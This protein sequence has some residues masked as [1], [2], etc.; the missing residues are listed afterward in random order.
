MGLEENAPGSAEEVGVSSCV[1]GAFSGGLLGI[2]FFQL[3]CNF[4]SVSSIFSIKIAEA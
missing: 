3:L 4:M 2:Y 1:A